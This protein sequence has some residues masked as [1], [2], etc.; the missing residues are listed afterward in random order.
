M[1]LSQQPNKALI[2]MTISDTN[3]ATRSPAHHSPIGRR[4]RN[5]R[6]QKKSPNTPDVLGNDKNRLGEPKRLEGRVRRIQD[7]IRI[8]FSQ[9]RLLTLRPPKD[10]R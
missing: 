10:N 3:E 9:I 2:F 6:Q 8:R 7:D 4:E 1:T 5:D